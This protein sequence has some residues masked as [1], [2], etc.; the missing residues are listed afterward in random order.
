MWFVYTTE[1]Y[2]DTKRNELLIFTTVQMD[3][4]IISAQGRK[5]GTKTI[6]CM[7]PFVYNSRKCKLFY[8]CTVTES[9]AGCTW[10]AGRD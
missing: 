9:R 7:L 5:P 3:L 2:P 8:L 6:W 1:H 4:K 10:G